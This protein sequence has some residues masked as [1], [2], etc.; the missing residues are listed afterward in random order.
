MG[1]KLSFVATDVRIEEQRNDEQFATLYVNA[2]ASG[3]NRNNTYVSDETLQKT[4]WTILDKP[5]LWAYDKKTN[6]VGSHERDEVPCGFI[7]SSNNNLSFTR[8]EDG[9][10]MLSVVAKVWKYYSGFL[11]DFFKRDESQK[12][13]S[14]E[15]EVIDSEYR[16]D[17]AWEL[18]DYIYTGITILGT[19]VMPAI[20][21]AKALVLNFSQATEE[22]NRAYEKEVSKLSAATSEIMEEGDSIVNIENK[23]LLGEL[24]KDIE[25]PEE[26][27]KTEPAD[28]SFAVEE[29]A[30]NDESFSEPQEQSVEETIVEE[31]S[32]QESEP[33]I[34]EDLA[35]SSVEKSVQPELPFSEI[36]EHFINVEG[37][38]EL[39][40]SENSFK[41][42]TFLYEK[43]LEAE[44]ELQIY[45]SENIELKELK[46]AIDK[47][48]LKKEINDTMS[49]VKD[50]LSEEENA[51]L[52]EAS[53]AYSIDNIN[54]WKNEAMATAYKASLK[55]KPQAKSD[56]SASIPEKRE[57]KS[58]V[59]LLW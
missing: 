59:K 22:F 46:A 18:S 50:S 6:D 14:V 20:P 7:P 17:G 49:V 24:E 13:V 28:D 47:E 3:H 23:T 36:T 11:M 54:T 1:K 2:F 4:A 25:K 9:R 44:N 30:Q 19:K 16:D 8:L 26:L 37:I 5:L 53:R 52:L 45:K 39:F 12:P 56:M 38:S 40:S 15:L 43:L 58:G 51:I 42:I 31:A 55:N 32:L 48:Q 35:E 41:A 34:N 57:K 27:S 21:G 29:A 10:T 33:P